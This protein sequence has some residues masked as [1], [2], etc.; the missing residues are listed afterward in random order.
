MM[1]KEDLAVL[2]PTENSRRHGRNATVTTPIP[3]RFWQTA[4]H[5]PRISHTSRVLYAGKCR[6]SFER[7]ATRT[8]D[9]RRWF[10]NYLQHGTRRNNGAVSWAVFWKLRKRPGIPFHPQMLEIVGWRRMVSGVFRG[11]WHLRYQTGKEEIRQ[12]HTY[13]RWY[14]QKNLT[15]EI[16]CGKFKQNFLSTVQ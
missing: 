14:Q 2:C 3:P 9:D 5:L 6:I 4:A 12:S 10:A 7:F 15:R 11:I 8:Y 16:Y 1:N 13:E